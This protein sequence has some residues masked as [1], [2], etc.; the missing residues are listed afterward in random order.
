MTWTVRAGPPSVHALGLAAV[1]VV[2]L[3]AAAVLPLDASPLSLLACPFRAATGWPCLTCGC[4]HAFAAF[5]HL[6]PVSALEASPLGA[7]L[8]LACAVHVGWTLLRLCGLRRAPAA[9]AVTPR[10]RAAA[11]ALLAA[12]WIFLALHRSP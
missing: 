10:V 2:L 1:G 3:G 9:V 5:V 12:N 7:A 8:A 6:H 11:L 4:T